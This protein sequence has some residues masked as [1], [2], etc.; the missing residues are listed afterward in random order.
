MMVKSRALTLLAVTALLL[1]ACGSLGRGP[2]PLP[3]AT[4]PSGTV[5]PPRRLD[6]I[7]DAVPRKEPRSRYGN[8]ETYE[9]FGRTYRVKRS[10]RGHV[11]RGT[12]SW[13]GPGFHAERTSSGEPYDMYAMTAAHKTLPIPVYARVTNLEN[14]RSVVV[15]V[16]DRGP[17]VGDRIIDLSYTAAHKLDMVRKGTAPVEIRVIEAGDEATPAPA[18]APVSTPASTPAPAPAIAA[19]AASPSAAADIGVSSR[20]LQTGSFAAREN[21]EAMVN[22]LA[23]SGIRNASVREARLGERAVFRVRVGPLDD[24]IEADDMIERLRV[25]GIPD[26]RPAHE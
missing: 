22:L 23:R 18:P 17:F 10:A 13:Y 4:V 2:E 1:Q 24:A 7:P 14:G 3:R 15:R 11:E 26:A 12:A 9:V 8:P 21:A 6:D 20:Y 5:K 25:A 16:N 19:A